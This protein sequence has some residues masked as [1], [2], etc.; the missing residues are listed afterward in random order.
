MIEKP[1]LKFLTFEKKIVVKF[2][3]FDLSHKT[4]FFGAVNPI[5]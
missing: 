2:Q 3:T 4:P 5:N 1:V